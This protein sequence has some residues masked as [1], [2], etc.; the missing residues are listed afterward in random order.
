MAKPVLH[1]ICNAHLDPVWQWRWEEGAAEAVTTFSIAARLLDE[2]PGFVFNHNEAILYRWVQEL[3]P[4]LFTLIQR[5]VR[6]G[7]W[8]ISGGW[9]LQPDVNMPGTEALIRH[10]AEG[11]RYFREY[12]DA[13]PVVAYNLD[14]FGHSGG[15]PQ[16]LAQAGYALYVHM[17]P[18]KKYLDLPSD[19]YRWQGTD[20][21]EIGGYR[22]P[23]PAYNT[24]P[25]TVLERIRQA[26]EIALRLNRDTPVFWGMGDHGGG[27]A[28]ADLEQIQ[29]LMQRET[30]LR[31]VHSSTEQYYQAIRHL[32]PAAPLIRGDLQRVFTGCYTSMARLKR[33]M[34]K[35]L[36][37]LLQTECARTTSWWLR[38]Q[39]YPEA[40]LRDAWRDHLFND[41]HDI[42]PGSSIEAGEL[43]ALDLYGRSSETLRR[44]RL[45][46]VS[47]FTHGAAQ[48]LH[49]PLTVLNTNPG[50]A[51]LP[52]ELEYMI[53]H[54]PRLEGKWHARLFTLD[55]TEIPVQEERAEM[56][57][58]VDQWRRKLCFSTPLPH[59]GSAH[60]RVEM[61]EG[62]AVQPAAEATLKHRIHPVTGRVDSLHTGDGRELLSGELLR[63]LVVNDDADSWGMEQWSYRDVEGEFTPVPGSSCTVESGPIRTIRETEYTYGKSSIVIRTLSYAAHPFLEFHLRILWNEKRKRLKLSI[64]TRITSTSLLC[65][66]PGGA[67]QRPADGE[68][69]THGRWM[70]LSGLV[71]GKNASMAVVNNGQ[72]GFDC[73]DGEVR[74]SVVRS[75]PYCYE[76]TFDLGGHRQQKLMDLGVHDMRLLIAVEHDQPLPPHLSAFADW[77]NAPP[78]ALAHYPIGKGTPA[79][80]ELMTLEGTSLRLLACKQSWDGT[81]LI[82]RVQE[83]IGV[84]TR[85]ILHIQQPKRDIGMEFRPFEIKTIRIE[86]DGSWREVR[87]IEEA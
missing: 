38:G 70:L 84:A 11:R 17:R 5:L 50:G 3:D 8:C 47:G 20:G 34:E 13:S 81:A 65:E 39:A 44:L 6:E 1:L 73:K 37:E 30:R 46:A 82:I 7:R 53:D 33:R 35:N 52:V 43:D 45:G 29:E 54:L 41:F 67:M 87:I 16:I 4:A 27:A 12:F 83:T 71:D 15:L 74:L 58:L 32:I 60:F 36:G 26:T 62:P 72:H 28:R 55:G 57:L 78:F 14:S 76:H 19:L 68:E 63:A 40:L 42:L 10:I 2:F 75:A 86:P 9:D 61:H 64:P 66:V 21:T 23:F 51:T 24:F 18:E 69:H 80:Q 49:I 25:G 56:L 79:R 48:P 59:V 22:I 85:G 31:I 77:L